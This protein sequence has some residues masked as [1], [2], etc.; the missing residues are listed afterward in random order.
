MMMRLEGKVAIITGAGQ[1]RGDSIGNGRAAAL[2][3]AR[4]GAKLLLA[5]R[6]T[7]SLDETLELLRKE[8]LDAEC[9]KADISKEDDCAALMKIAV[10]KFGRID[11]LHNNVGIGAAD[12][13]TTKI[14]RQVWD[15][16][17]DVNL[18]GAML[19][20]KHVLPIMRSQKQ[21]SITHVSSV[22]AIASYPLIAYKASKAAL[23]EFVRWLAFENAP[24]NIRCN[25][26]MLGM[27]DTPMAIEGYHAAT[28][29][30]REDIRK[31][32]D[33][34]VPL[35]RMGTAWETAKAAVFLASDE[36]SYITGAVIPVDGGLHTRVG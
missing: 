3:F 13:D 21:G 34:T 15:K 32:R 23:H 19:V 2:L 17:F 36:A 25:V 27:I 16:M 8:G 26:L 20:S 10:S 31:Q 6:S 11:I 28:G 29:V 18:N 5:N 9:T 33:K 1:T 4:E 12:G 14:D 24:H 22:A 7:A 35:G 30:S